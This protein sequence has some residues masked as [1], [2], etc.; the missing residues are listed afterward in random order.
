MKDTPVDSVSLES[1]FVTY[2]N[3]SLH[4]YRYGSG[5]QWLFCF[6]GYGENGNSFSFLKKSLGSDYTL[7]ALDFPFHGDTSWNEGLLFT[8][9]D[10]L[11]IVYMIMQEPVQSINL[12]GYSMGGR[13][14]LNLLPIIPGKIGKVV[15]I[16]PDGLNPNLW[17]TL[18]TQTVW[19]NRLFSFTMHHPKWFFT[20]IK[21]AFAIRVINKSIFNFV[22][23]HLDY[24][25]SRVL[26]YERWTTMR[27]FNTPVPL[28]KKT[29]L[30]K[31]I[32]INILF[33]KFD[34][35]ITA[36]RGVE[37]Q[38]GIEKQVTIAELEAGHQL[39]KEK[40][41]DNIMDLFRG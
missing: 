28:L 40:Y 37:F 23:Y 2:K 22:H 30:Q 38:K 21:L 41:T 27:K 26:L 16:A 15:L 35:I 4:Y 34:R 7:I 3:S 39:L 19:G 14:A 24:H 33:G 32:K 8:A 13:V 9:T 12:L 31:A 25:E 5:K 6:H 11:Q 10:L 20:L 18:A 1:K 29:I 17:H 36:K